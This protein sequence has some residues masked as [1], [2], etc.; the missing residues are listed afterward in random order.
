MISSSGQ[1][2]D[3]L[4]FVYGTLRPCSN[5]A[6]AR[7]LASEARYVGPARVRGRLYDLGYYPGLRCARSTRDWV[8]G[9]LYALRCVAKAL[10][11]LDRYEGLSRGR[12]GARFVRTRTAVVVQHGARRACF[13][14]CVAWLYAY[15]LPVPQRAAVCSGDYRERLRGG[16]LGSPAT[17]SL[18]R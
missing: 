16:A 5:T 14:R 9:D 13:R 2:R 18:S 6:M 3:S 8:L 1:K 7:W 12:A 17:S 15:R 11:A 10:R 4:L